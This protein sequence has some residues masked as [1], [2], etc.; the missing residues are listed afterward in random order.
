[1][2]SRRSPQALLELLLAGGILQ[3]DPV[4]LCLLMIAF[5]FSNCV[6]VKCANPGILRQVR[7]V[8]LAE[9]AEFWQVGASCRAMCCR[10]VPCGAVRCRAVLCWWHALVLWCMVCGWC[11]AVWCNA[12]LPVVPCLCLSSRS[13]Q[14]CE[15]VHARNKDYVAVA[16]CYMRDVARRVQVCRRVRI[17]SIATI[18]LARVACAWC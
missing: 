9:R 4:R 13:Q 10:M 7:L 15:L 17:N 18:P 3:F 16:Q 1:M 11:C 14:V 2:L 12:V 8:R 6:L 5:L